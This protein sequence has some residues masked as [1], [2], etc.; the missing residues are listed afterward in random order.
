VHSPL[1]LLSVPL[2]PLFLL[3][4]RRF[5]LRRRFR[6]PLLVSAEPV[7]EPAQTHPIHNRSHADERL[8]RLLVSLAARLRQKDVDEDKAENADAAVEEEGGAE[9]EVGLDV[10]K[11]LGDDK[12]A[13]VR[14]EV[15]H[16]VGP[17]TRAHWQ[18]L[19]EGRAR[20]RI[21]NHTVVGNVL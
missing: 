8:R 2:H 21:L 14:G 10:L 19:G 20:A 7:G 1:F 6:S 12:P 9:P 5:C 13:E 4:R 15:G 16:R 17:A 3:L 11:G 18:H